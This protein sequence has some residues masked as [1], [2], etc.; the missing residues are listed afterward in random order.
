MKNYSY[1]YEWDVEYCYPDSN[2]LKNKLN[3][4]NAEDLAVAEREITSIKLAYAKQNIIEGD[5]DF[6][7]L[8]KIHKFLFEDIYE[9][10]GE[11]RHVNISKGNQFC[12]CQNL[13][14]YADTIFAC[15]KKDNYLKNCDNVPERLAYYLSEINVL[16][17]FREGNGRAQRLFIEYLALN[18]CYRVDFSSVSPEEMIVASAEAF[19]CE[20][21]KINEMFE[22]ITTK[23]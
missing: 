12:L 22:R 18:S 15:L 1:D 16:H 2:V 10:A 7:H 13:E 9:W 17:P 5:F 6:S 19:A 14:A 23:L 11:Y 8:R 21:D 3:I 20:Y 4:T